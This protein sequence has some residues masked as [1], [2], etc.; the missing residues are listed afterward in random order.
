LA[1]RFSSELNMRFVSFHNRV[2]YHIMSSS[3]EIDIYGIEWVA[4]DIKF[5]S[6][7]I[8]DNSKYPIP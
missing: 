1:G 3:Y 8:H 7:M 6:V 5:E 2:K 4:V